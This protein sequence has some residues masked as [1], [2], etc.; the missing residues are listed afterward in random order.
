MSTVEKSFRLARMSPLI[1]YLTVGLLVLPLL[2]LLISAV[3]GK[4]VLVVPA[5]LVAVIYSWVWARFR[6]T[7]F[8]VHADALEVVWPLKRRR[9]GRGEIS[10]VRLI[11]SR[12]LRRETGRCMRV[13]AGGL[14]GGFGCLYTQRRG[15][16]QMYISRTDHFVWIERVD[17]R[18]WLITPDQPQAFVQALSTVPSGVPAAS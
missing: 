10:E 8:V 5:L 12:E 11:D 16:V 6:P 1:L 18:P 14:W 4:W 15:I 3:S 13:G 2:F 9:I 7:L 17:D